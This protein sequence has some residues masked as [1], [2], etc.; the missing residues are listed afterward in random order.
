MSAFTTSVLIMAGIYGA[1]MLAIGVYFFREGIDTLDDYITAG[2]NAGGGFPM[3]IVAASLL[4]TNNGNANVLGL[5]EL[6]FNSGFG[7][8]FWI[9]TGVVIVYSTMIYDGP[10]L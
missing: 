9:V 2:R 3:A 7:N 10:K 8:L 5:P 1:V 6:A 4:A